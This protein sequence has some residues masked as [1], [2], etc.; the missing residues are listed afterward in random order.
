MIAPIGIGSDG[1]DL[2]HQRRPRRGQAR[3]DPAGREAGRAH[4]HAGRARQERQAADRPHAE[5]DRRP[6]RR[7]RDLTA[8]CCP[9]SARR[10]TR[11]QNGVKSVHIIDGRVRARAAARSADRPRASARSSKQVA[12]RRHLEASRPSRRVW[13][14]DLDNTL[15]D[16]TPHIFPSMHGQIDAL[17]ADAARPRRRRRE[18][19][20]ASDFWQRYGATL[21]GLMRHHGTDPR[22][23]LCRNAPVSGARAT[24]WCTRTRSSTRCVRLGGTRL[25]FSNAPRHY[26][27]E[28][29]R[30]HRPGALL[31]RGLLHRGHALP[32]QAGTLGFPSRCCASTTSIRTAAPWSTTSSRTCA[33]RSG[34]A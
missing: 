20:C 9:R 34:W 24:W 17:P 11:A 23:F 19:A 15:H 2:Q 1:D 4:Q 14:F 18:R 26:V 28:V 33:P 13:I 31:R 3:R 12:L 5:E 22:H 8:A 10:S 30:A 25:V 7:R 6:G 16:A 32:R 27:E 21:L 29:L